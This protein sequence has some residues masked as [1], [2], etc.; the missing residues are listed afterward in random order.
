M[1]IHKPQLL[2]VLFAF[3]NAVVQLFFGNRLPKKILS[4]VFIMEGTDKI[5]YLINI[6]LSA[7]SLN[8]GSTCFGKIVKS[9]NKMSDSIVGLAFDSQ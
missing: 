2:N 1:V 4:K 5:L 3:S 8:K 9:E 7:A 6:T